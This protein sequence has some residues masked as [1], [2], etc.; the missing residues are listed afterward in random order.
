MKEA[1]ATTA[2]FFVIKIQKKNKFITERSVFN[3]K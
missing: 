1:V 2:S 3:K